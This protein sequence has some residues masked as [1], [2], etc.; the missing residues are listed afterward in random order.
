MILVTPWIFK[1]TLQS[2]VI[3]ALAD[4]FSSQDSDESPGLPP[5]AS[6]LWLLNVA[7]YVVIAMLSLRIV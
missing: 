1:I 7:H 3:S 6:K 4:H 5:N 2:V